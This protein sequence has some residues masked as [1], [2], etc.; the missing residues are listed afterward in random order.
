L[1]HAPEESMPQE[2]QALTEVP[3]DIY[4]ERKQNIIWLAAA[5]SVAIVLAL[6]AWL[7][8]GK[9]KGE[10]PPEAIVSGAQNAKVETLAL[11]DAMPVSA[12]PDTEPAAVMSGAEKHVEENPG[13]EKPKADVTMKTAEVKIAPQVVPSPQP[14]TVPL[15]KPQA[16]NPGATNNASA[17]AT[18]RMTFEADSWVEITDKNGKIL[19]S[20]LSRAGTEQGINGSPPFSLVIGHAKAVHLYYKGQ[21]VDL[22]P[23]TKIEVARLTLE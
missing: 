9:L 4:T 15:N 12:V 5:L 20:Q 7:F 1:P 18:I 10:N 13:I 17:Q 19:L 22:A 6:F 21:A 16:V 23:H 11:P 14:V 8:A 3:Y 2:A